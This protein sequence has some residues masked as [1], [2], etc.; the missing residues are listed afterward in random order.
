MTEMTSTDARY[1]IG[2]FVRQD[3]Y[4]AAE[5]TSCI[6]RLTA[7]PA[8]IAAAI[9][10]LSDNQLSQPYRP[11]GWTLRQL[12][13][14]VADSHLHMYIRVKLALS[15]N[16]PLINAYD[17]DAWA[18]MADVT[19]VSPMVSLSL[20]ATVHERIVAIFRSLSPDGFERALM[21]PDNGRMTVEQVL[22]M[23]AWHGDHHIAHLRAAQ[24]DGGTKG[25][26]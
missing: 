4:S 3:H 20:L 5:R 10:G 2:N 6:A 18:A 25:T 26:L 8:A 14:H 16:E 22:A 24:T 11:G 1:P 21:H 12:V 13:H 7:Q 19:A 17:Q 23:Y 15:A 9:S